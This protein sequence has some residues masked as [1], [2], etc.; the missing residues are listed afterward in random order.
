[1]KVNLRI[2]KNCYPKTY[3]Q[4]TL[5][6]LQFINTLQV[7]GINATFCNI[8]LQILHEKSNKP[9]NAPQRSTNKNSSDM[10][11][12]IYD[13]VFAAQHEGLTT[14]EATDQLLVLFGA[15]GRSEQLEAFREWYDS[16][17]QDELAWYEGRYEEVF[18]SL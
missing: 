14:K 17:S 6:E 13:I 9:Q 7:W 4:F 8:F 3:Y 5:I 16:L 15:V 2:Q 18:L 10:K 1:M 11:K 12:K